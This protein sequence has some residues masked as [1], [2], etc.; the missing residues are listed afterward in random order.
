VITSDLG[1]RC[2]GGYAGAEINIA[3]SGSGGP[4][5]G[6]ASDTLFQVQNGSWV[7]IGRSTANCA[8]VPTSVHVYCTVS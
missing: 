8:A 2:E 1:F 5:G 7:E 6:I 4:T 3:P